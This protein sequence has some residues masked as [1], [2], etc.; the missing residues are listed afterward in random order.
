MFSHCFLLYSI[1]EENQ[2]E[3]KL[4]QKEHLQWLQK[5]RTA[6]LWVQCDEC[7]RWRFLPH[8]LDNHELPDK[9]YCH[10]NPGNLHTPI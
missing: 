6:G 1:N 10:I 2:S 3:V 4:T 9:W 5:Q 7:N 8:V